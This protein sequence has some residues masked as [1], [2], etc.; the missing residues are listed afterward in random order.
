[1]QTEIQNK[2]KILAELMT[3]ILQAPLDPID[4][5]IKTMQ[6]DLLDTQDEIKKIDELVMPSLT[7]LIEDVGKVDKKFRIIIEKIEDDFPKLTFQLQDKIEKLSAD[8]HQAFASVIIENAAQSNN[9]LKSNFEDIVKLVSSTTSTQKES[10]LSISNALQGLNSATEDVKTAQA[11]AIQD[12]IKKIHLA[13]DFSEKK[14]TSIAVQLETFRETV[15]ARLDNFSVENKNALTEQR[16][17]KQETLELLGC[18][19][20]VT[21]TLLTQQHAALQTQILA[22]QAALQEIRSAKDFSEKNSASLAMKFETVSNAV[23]ARLDAIS[24]ENKNTLT[25]QRISK[26]E[27]SEILKQ[28]HFVTG[29]LLT[30]QHE[31]LR[32]QINLCQHKLKSQAITVGVFFFSMLAY[33]GFDIVSNLK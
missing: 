11:L 23:A 21:G 15:A 4:K 12:V 20:A 5:S 8:Q 22:T 17:N 33:I 31:A 27:I 3:R 9:L 30:Q 28:S 2:E 24:V 7:A 16:L 26:Q 10:F 13:Q 6:S 1:M 29:K 19:H 32:A 25:E 18:N 14:S